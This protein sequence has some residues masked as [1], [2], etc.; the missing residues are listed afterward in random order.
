V[1]RV[2]SRGNGGRDGRDEV[3]EGLEGHGEN[4]P[5]VRWRFA[6]YVGLPD[7]VVLII[8]IGVIGGRKIGQRDS[9]VLLADLRNWQNIEEHTR[10]RIR[11]PQTFPISMILSWFNC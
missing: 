6:Q 10:M 9:L 2:V 7:A 5:W 4:E 1:Q 3:Q 8:E 11:M